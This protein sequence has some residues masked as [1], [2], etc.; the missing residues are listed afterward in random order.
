VIDEIVC[1]SRL[2][3]EIISKVIDSGKERGRNEKS[4]MEELQ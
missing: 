3:S 2:F 1:K 4:K